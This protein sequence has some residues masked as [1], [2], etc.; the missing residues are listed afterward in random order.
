MEL[1]KSLGELSRLHAFADGPVDA[2][3][4]PDVELLIMQ[5]ALITFAKSP[6]GT[7]VGGW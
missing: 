4:N 7:T 6:P 1:L 3:L 2:G 5:T